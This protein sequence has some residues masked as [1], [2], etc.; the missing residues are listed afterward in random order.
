MHL[1]GTFI[2]VPILFLYK[3]TNHMTR[4]N[5]GFYDIY[6]DI[7]KSI[8]LIDLC[9][10]VTIISIFILEEIKLILAYY[11]PNYMMKHACSNDLD[12]I[13]H[14]AYLFNNRNFNNVH[15]LLESC[16]DNRS[17]DCFKFIYLTHPEITFESKY[18]Y[19]KKSIEH[20]HKETFL[21]IIDDIP[22]PS[23]T[24]YLNHNYIY[25]DNSEQDMFWIIH[26]KIIDKS[27]INYS[28]L[29]YRSYHDYN[30]K[31][32]KEI[33]KIQ[34]IKININM[35]D[36]GY[37]PRNK[38]MLSLLL[39]QSPIITFKANKYMGLYYRW[40]K[41]SKKKKSAKS[42]KLTKQAIDYVEQHCIY[43]NELLNFDIK[44]FIKN[45]KMFGKIT[46]NV[47]SVLYD[48]HNIYKDRM[49]QRFD[50]IKN[51]LV[52]LTCLL[53][54]DPMFDFHILENELIDYI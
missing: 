34:E 43:Q 11:F 44:T 35:L 46:Y 5:T 10:I 37:N 41:Y 3:E 33:Y 17:F 24:F 8:K 29:F 22:Q 51:V 12:D 40:S 48:L 15:E 52:P 26:D 19:F 27:K 18:R 20:N 14:L 36:C 28:S 39:K 2:L 21:M 23:L 13:L 4:D 25:F 53:K 9:L 50:Y 31:I 38:Y 49:N 47:N 54:K 6:S 45:I 16:C 30:I 42:Y 32:C 1:I 7:Y